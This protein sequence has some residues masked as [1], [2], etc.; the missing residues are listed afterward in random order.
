MRSESILSGEADQR[1]AAEAFHP[2]DFVKEE[3]GARGWSMETL[4]EV[5]QLD[6]QLLEEVI[7]GHRSITPIIALGLSRAF[8]TGRQVWLNLNETWKRAQA[9]KD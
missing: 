4:I 8:G 6:R 2:G 5:S 3:M 1:I 9:A 7:A